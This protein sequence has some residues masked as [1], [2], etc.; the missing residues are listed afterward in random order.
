MNKVITQLKEFIQS[1]FEWKTYL[2]TFVFITTAITIN[3]TFG[4][5]NKIIYNHPDMKVIMIRFLGFYMLAYFAIAIPKMCIQNKQYLF[6]NPVFWVKISL[7]LLLISI[8]SG[9]QFEYNWFSAISDSQ[10]RLFVL[11]LSSQLKCLFLYTFPLIVMCRIFDKNQ[12]GIYGLSWRFGN[13]SVYLKMLMIMIPI[14]V[15]ASFTPDFI[16]AYPRY[17]VWQFE[18]MDILPVWASTSIFEFLYVVDFTM[19]EWMFRGALVLGMVAI[20]GKDAVLPMVSVYVFLHFG[21]P[22]GETIGAFFGGYILG[23]LAYTTRH[24]WG[25]VLIHAGVAL[26]MEFMGFFQ[27]YVMGIHR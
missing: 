5:E 9:F 18:T 27:Y 10:T 1:D 20:M 25:G 6:A 24:I 13:G 12:E 21:K 14:I 15:I 7:F 3:Y 19:T 16:Q 11:K 2:W 4:F 22:L 8:T 17:K 23:V 26:I